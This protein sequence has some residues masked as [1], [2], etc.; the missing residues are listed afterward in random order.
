MA[1][2]YTINFDKSD[3]SVSLPS[4][5]AR[6]VTGEQTKQQR[7]G[8]GALHGG[9]A[10][11]ELDGFTPPPAGTYATYRKI[12]AYPTVALAIATVTAP[13]IAS[14]WVWKNKPKTPKRWLKFLS[15][16]LDPMRDQ[17]MRDAL[18]ALVFGWQGF[19]KVWNEKEGRLVLSKLKPQIH[20]HTQI[21]IDRNGN[22]V[23][24]RNSPPGGGEAAN[25]M[26][27]KFWLYTNDPAEGPYGR[28]RHENIREHWHNARQVEQRLAQ[29]LKKIANIVVQLHYPEG[30]AQDAS[31]ATRSNDEIAQQIIEAVTS[32]KSVRMQNLFAACDINNPS[33][34][35][36]AAKLAGQSQWV[37]SAFEAAG[38]N[39]AAGLLDSLAYYDKEIFRGW[40]RP[41][42]T[43]LEGEHGTQAEAQ[44]VTNTGL[45]ESELVD[46]DVI[47]AFNR[48]VV[49]DIL[50]LNFGERARGA[51]YID[52]TPLSDAAERRASLIIRA[53][54]SNKIIAGGLAKKI[55]W[56][57]EL[58]NGNISLLEGAEGPIE[59][60]LEAEQSKKNRTG[61]ANESGDHSDAD[62][63]DTN[64]NGN[65]RMDHMTP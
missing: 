47:S 58:R 55:D 19:E 46:R 26:G 33:D 10:R 1:E 3:E 52:P 65:G 17:V 5:P 6:P 12:S 48:G 16:M 41:E 28:S 9:Y 50:V 61:E 30:Q 42:R 4:A 20:D 29:Y 2:L 40:L 15:N 54:L 23:G 24:L 7:R 53:G 22:P 45:I 39:H 35:E 27:S 34:L 8:D 44:V 25:L 36:V 60:D 32:G 62:P 56:D 64:S 14:K 63:V 57:T 31:G 13:V 43:G 49:D 21:W 37:L 11:S 59:L 38:T 18:R 51:V